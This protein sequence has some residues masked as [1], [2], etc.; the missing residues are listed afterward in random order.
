MSEVTMDLADAL[1]VRSR[2]IPAILKLAKERG[3]TD[4]Q[5]I[6]N[7]NSQNAN[8]W[9]IGDPRWTQET[10]NNLRSQDNIPAAMLTAWYRWFDNVPRLT[11][12]DWNNGTLAKLGN[13][14]TLYVRNDGFCTVFT[15]D[16]NLNEVAAL[17]PTIAADFA[18]HFGYVKPA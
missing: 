17:D 12:L 18:A 15:R 1:I 13:G 2:D 5:L 3:W 4:E 6:Y 11:I 9:G 8:A 16:Q 7:Y 14:V 10:L